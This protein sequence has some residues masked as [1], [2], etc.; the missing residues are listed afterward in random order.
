VTSEKNFWVR[1]RRLSQ[2]AFHKK[3]IEAYAEKMVQHAHQMSELFKDQENRD[4]HRDMMELTLQIVVKTLFSADIQG[5]EKEVGISMEGVM[6]EFM[7]KF[8]SLF[9]I[10]LSVPTPSNLR[11]KN[12]IANLDRI[13]YQIIQE[14]RTVK[15]KKEDLLQM[16]LNARDEDETHMSDR[17]LR[18]E[19][20]TLFIAGHETTANTLAYTWY[21]L[22]NHP[23]V[24]QKL[25]KELQEVLNNRLPTLVDLDQLQYTKKLFRN[26]CV[27]FRR[28]GSLVEN[29]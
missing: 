10:P 22:A 1:Q 18:D 6:K 21:L 11:L 25:T 17:Q 8:N 5:E 20:M 28:L 7:N 4:I 29:L 27:Y 14:R 26:P 3:R 15:T 13:I 2:P 9:K 24:E 23:E 16:L 19:I 12:L